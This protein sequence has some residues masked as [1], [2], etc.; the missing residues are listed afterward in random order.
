MFQIGDKVATV[1]D[2]EILAN[3]G[4]DSFNIYKDYIVSSINNDTVVGGELCDIHLRALDNSLIVGAL[5]S[6]YLVLVKSP[7]AVPLPPSYPP[8]VDTKPTNPKDIAA[9]TRLDLS[10]FPDTAVVYGALGMTEGAYKYGAYNYR[11]NGVL[12][13]IYY[14]AARRHMMK[15][16]AGAW[17]D[18]KTGVPHL[19][20][21]LSCIA[22]IIDSHEKGNLVD[23]RPPVV[24]MERLLNE[25]QG[26]VK[27]LQD[28]FPD[29]KPRCVRAKD[30]TDNG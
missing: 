30:V 23:D 12:V 11:V 18:P 19:A 13:S 17:S 21:A 5:P 2:R 14:A 27:H 24:D 10:V 20:S 3:I 28:T 8:S 26:K 16:F 9:T 4:L 29:P 6:S 1:A 22:I 7:S 25:M 15:Y